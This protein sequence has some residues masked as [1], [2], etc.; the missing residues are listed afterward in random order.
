MGVLIREELSPF[1]PPLSHLASGSKDNKLCYSLWTDQD[2]T[3]EGLILSVVMWIHSCCFRTTLVWVGWWRWAVYL[4]ASELGFWTWTVPL[5][6]RLQPE[7]LSVMLQSHW[8][9]GHLV[10][11][12]LVAHGCAAR[13]IHE[14]PPSPPNQTSV[15]PEL[16]FCSML[17]FSY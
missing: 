14:R 9:G 11:G 6:G 7:L 13:D 2:L 15:S 1:F 16:F 3:G 10:Q 4:L 5:E 12:N 17:S 8:D